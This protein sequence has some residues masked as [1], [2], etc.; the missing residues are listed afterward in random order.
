MQIGKQGMNSRL[1]HMCQTEPDIENI[2]HSFPSH[3]QA[4]HAF[5][6]KA[7]K[8]H[9]L[10]SSQNHCKFHCGSLMRR[11]KTFKHKNVMENLR[12]QNPQDTFS[13]L[14]PSTRNPSPRLKP[15]NC[16][17]SHWAVVFFLGRCCIGPVGT[18]QAL[19]QVPPR[20]TLRGL[21]H[22]HLFGGSD[23]K[24]LFSHPDLDLLKTSS[25]SGYVLHSFDACGRRF[26]LA[27]VGFRYLVLCQGFES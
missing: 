24:V 22:F 2:P 6:P 17:T 20:L 19:H 12:L 16:T 5:Q 9:S 25:G 7:P 15:G 27:V 4:E 11:Y 23:L 8:L 14:E 18:Q 13:D 10:G 3:V 21:L 26:G 1:C